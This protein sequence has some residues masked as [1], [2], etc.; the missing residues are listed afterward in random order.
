MAKRG[1]EVERKGKK[2]KEKLK[3]N[4]IDIQN[5]IKK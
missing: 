3:E 4:N 5:R 1:E 2:A